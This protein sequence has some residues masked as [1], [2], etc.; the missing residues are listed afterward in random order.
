MPTCC[1]ILAA[2]SVGA[3][4]EPGIAEMPP[5]LDKVIAATRII[6]VDRLDPADAWLE[7]A[8]AFSLKR[9]TV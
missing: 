8:Y 5:L 1:S 7:F 2:A 6:L 3:S 9:R 4:Q